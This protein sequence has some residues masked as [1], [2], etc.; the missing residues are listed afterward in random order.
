M[1]K[2]NCAL[3]LAGHG[4]TLNPDS[5]EPTHQHAATLRKRGIFSEVHSCF[6]KEE[7]SFRQIWRIV[8]AD[9]VYIVPNFISEGYFTQTILPREFGLDGALTERDGKIIKYCEPVGSHANMTGLILQR[10]REV[11][12]GVDLKQSSLVIVGHGTGLNEN[13]AQAIRDQVARIRQLEEFGE[14]V[15]A[16]MEETPAVAE[17]DQL[18][19]LEHVI[20]VPF[21]IADGLHSYE[22]IP[23]LLGMAP[24]PMGAVSQI[25]LFWQ[26]PIALRGRKLYYASAI[27]TS[28][29]LADVILDQVRAFDEK[30][31]LAG[32]V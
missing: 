16:F 11:A 5:S 9:E 1:Q 17:W 2:T 23:V 28:P 3:I 21:F 25:G 29:L 31:T 26:N 13:S 30:H 32:T 27:G 6:W 20:V 24:Q 18:T 22:D 12:P 7:P 19:T 14:V 4:S 15:D 10:A 8:E